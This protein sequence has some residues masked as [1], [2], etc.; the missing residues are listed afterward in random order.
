MT[1]PFPRSAPGPSLGF[2]VTGADHDPLSVGPTLRL[3]TAI[4]ESTGTRVHA[5]A[6]RWQNMNKAC[7]RSAN[8]M[9][10]TDRHSLHVEVLYISYIR[11]A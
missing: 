7:R 1:L 6:L 9:S 2:A 4:T 5:L 11:L 10:R 3:H 8:R